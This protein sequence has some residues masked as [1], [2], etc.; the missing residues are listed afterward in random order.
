MVHM[1]VGMDNA[2][3]MEAQRAWEERYGN[4]NDFMR[5][6]GRSYLGSINDTTEE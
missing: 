1:D 4:R 3:K 5:V 6:F 2:L